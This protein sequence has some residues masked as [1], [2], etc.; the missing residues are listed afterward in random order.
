M[1]ERLLVATRKGLFTVE[2]GRPSDA[3]RISRAAFVGDA[4][5]IVLHDPRNGWVYAALGHG[6][7]GTKLHRSR[8][9]GTTWEECAAPAYPPKPEGVEDIKC[10]ARGTVI[11]WSLELIWSLETGGTDEP[12][13]LW[14]GTVPGGLF[15]SD[16]HGTSWRLV[17]PLWN[18]PRRKHWFGGGMDLPGI[19]SVCVDPRDSRHVTIGISC[20]GVWVTPDR[21]ASWS[22]QAE[23][24]FAA[25]MP[26]EMRNDPNIQDPHCIA[27]CLCAP[28]HLW[29]Q[30]HNGVFRSTD[31]ARSWQ[32]VPT[33]R[34]STF[35]FPVV[36]H[37]RD[38]E[39]AWFVPAVSDEKRVPVNGQVVVSRTRD[40]GRTFTELRHG[41]PQEHAYD[42]AFRHSLDVNETGD[43]LAFGSTTGS[44]WITEDQ[45]D[46]WH[47]VSSHL[48]PVYCVRFV[49]PPA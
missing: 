1:S 8:D 22:L 16:D 29:V 5:S 20:G 17:E 25:Y 47:T 32:E 4:V 6:H 46:H 12:G 41:L 48:P 35:G 11:P 38:P 33:V 13:A 15:R 21:G 30:H 7:F 2:R 43:R 10:P 28:D 36:V 9:G 39:T 27:Q 40:G 26:P 14:C 37:P 34:P 24:M 23:G 19:H 44:L 49:K 45:G 3:W 18:E 42:I 31:G